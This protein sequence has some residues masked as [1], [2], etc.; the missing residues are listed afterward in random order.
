MTMLFNSSLYL[1]SPCSSDFNHC[2]YSSNY[3]SMASSTDNTSTTSLDFAILE[4]T[5]TSV[6]RFSSQY[7]ANQSHS[8]I[9]ENVCSPAQIYPSYGDSTNALVFRTYGPWW[10][11]MPSYREMYTKH[12]S[13][14]ESTFTSRDFIEIEF[15]NAI[16]RCISLNIYE[17]YNPG[18]VNVVYAGEQL[19]DEKIK[20]HRIWK[21]P[22]TFSI[23]LK[24]KQ[25]FII[26]NG[27]RIQMKMC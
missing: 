1:M 11:N 9:V 27:M 19:D 21:F 7:G 20:W 12:F 26:E 6:R 15:I 18:T 4:Q 8:Y 17:T 10:I 3:L 2:R 16:D 5:P 13:R 25:E 22:E 23:V 14:N 24:N